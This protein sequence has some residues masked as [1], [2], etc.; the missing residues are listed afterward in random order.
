VAGGL[1]GT[2]GWTC[3]SADTAVGSTASETSSFG[4][5]MGI[6]SAR[7]GPPPLRQPA[8]RPATNQYASPPAKPC[9]AKT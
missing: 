5:A 2:T 9:K 8:K 1:A 3:G 7:I 6:G 4:R